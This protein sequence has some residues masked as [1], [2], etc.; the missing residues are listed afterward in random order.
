[1]ATTLR[2]RVAVDDAAVAG[3]QVSA[4]EREVAKGPRAMFSMLL[5]AV[6]ALGY[7]LQYGPP[8]SEL[9]RVPSL[10]PWQGGGSAAPDQA[11]ADAAPEADE[12]DTFSPGSRGSW[13][14]ID[15][16][17]PGEALRLELV[18]VDQSTFTHKS[19]FCDKIVVDSGD[20][21]RAL[22]D[23][24]QGISGEPPP[25]REAFVCSAAHFYVV[26]MQTFYSD[27]IIDFIMEHEG[28]NVDLFMGLLSA[29][30]CKPFKNGFLYYCAGEL[31]PEFVGG[32]T[33]TVLDYGSNAGFFTQMSAR[34]GYR[35][36]TVD[37]QPQCIQFVRAAAVANGVW[38]SVEL[39]NVFLSAGGVTADGKTHLPLNV[40]TGCMG[41]WPAPD[42]DKVRTFYDAIPG[43]AAIK[44]VPLV[45]PASL[46]TEQDLVVLAKIDIEGHE[47]DVLGALRPH[48]KAKRILN[49]MVELNK[50]AHSGGLDIEAGLREG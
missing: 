4:D 43:G 19:S 24:I 20:L 3:P 46:I 26:D 22:L 40:R 34:L 28:W 35:V 13:P 23:R 30:G 17:L 2:R 6:L 50:K 31:T 44:Q 33:L 49:L 38:S 21:Q 16:A 32:R 25:S 29:S 39:H 42:E 27:K 1:M 12:C 8:V 9:S 41:T 5:V 15:D 47:V 14:L 18:A 45:D 7:M 48:L 37:P 11:R 10:A 36:I